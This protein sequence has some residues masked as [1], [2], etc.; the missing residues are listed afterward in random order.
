MVTLCGLSSHH[1]HIYKLVNY[2][3]NNAGDTSAIIN[4]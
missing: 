3:G 4:E 2:A 1:M